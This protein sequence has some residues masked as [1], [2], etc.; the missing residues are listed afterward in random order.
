MTTAELHPLHQKILQHILNKGVMT[1]TVYRNMDRYAI[2]INGG[3]IN[4]EAGLF[5]YYGYMMW[6]LVSKCMA[7]VL[8]C[9]Y[10]A[11]FD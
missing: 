8:S 6:P 3:F 10:A 2:V 5:Y 9:N 1:S 4:A 11:M 7:A